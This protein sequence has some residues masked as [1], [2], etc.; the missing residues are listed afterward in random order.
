MGPAFTIHDNSVNHA[1]ENSNP[2][3]AC[4]CVWIPV[5][6]G[7]VFAFAGA[8][9]SLKCG[10]ARVLPCFVW[11]DPFD[12]IC[13][14]F[15][16]QS[17][18]EHLACGGMQ[19]T[20]KRSWP[21]QRKPNCLLPT[22]SAINESQNDK[23]ETTHK[24]NFFTELLASQESFNISHAFP[25]HFWPLPRPNRTTRQQS[26]QSDHTQSFTEAQT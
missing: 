21:S 12:G 23:L 20:R 11:H 4:L 16:H 3:L 8:H 13:F 7:T 25:Y 24:G 22:E 19:R 17:E 26:T 15:A 9:P 1:E 14:Q 18:E 5:F 2:Y 6:K 10:K